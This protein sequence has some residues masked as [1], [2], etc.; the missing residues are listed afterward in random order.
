MLLA[1]E[2]VAQHFYWLQTP[3]LYRTHETPEQDKMRALAAFVHGLGY[4]MKI[5]QEEIHPKELQK[6]LEQAEGTPEEN[7]IGPAY[8]KKHE[9]GALYHPL[10]RAFRTGEP[11]L[12]PFY[13]SDPQISGSADPPHH[14]GTAFRPSGRRTHGPL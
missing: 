8:F 10:R 1:N 3:F 13:L 9:A 11:V 2:T 6:L 14:K 7:L 12:L 5:G 4:S